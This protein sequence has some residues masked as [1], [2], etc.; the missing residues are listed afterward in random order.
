MH[1]VNYTVTGV[2]DS[3]GNIGLEKKRLNSPENV[4]PSILT[5]TLSSIV[6]AARIFN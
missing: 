5:S 2:L 1:R 6:P 3:E 4:E